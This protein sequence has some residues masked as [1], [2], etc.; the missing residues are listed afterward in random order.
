MYTCP[1]QVH[2][3]LTDNYCLHCCY[4]LRPAAFTTRGH[5]VRALLEAICFQSRDVLEAMMLDTAMHRAS[6]MARGLSGALDDEQQQQECGTGLSNGSSSSPRLAVVAAAA[7]ADLAP[8]GEEQP[9][10]A[11]VANGNSRSP[12]KQQQQGSGFSATL[13]VL[14]VDGGASHNDLLMQLQVGALT[15]GVVYLVI[16]LPTSSMHGATK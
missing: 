9:A 12:Q 15:A 11:A 16:T 6:S 1:L 7:A 10:A 3:T 8:Q 14:R 5:V 4:W 2:L 13:N